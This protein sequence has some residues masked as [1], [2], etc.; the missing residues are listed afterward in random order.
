MLE[1][2]NERNDS[3]I[4]LIDLQRVTGNYC[5]AKGN[6]YCRFDLCI[7]WPDNAGRKINPFTQR[8]DKFEHEVDKMLWSLIRYFLKDHKNWVWAQLRDNTRAKNDP[9]RIILYY[10]KGIVDVNRLKD[11]SL[12][13]QNFPLPDWLK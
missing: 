4:S 9:E 12:L 11:Y 8:G 5:T 1:S 2:I 10:N 13:L 7:R 6:F 3:A